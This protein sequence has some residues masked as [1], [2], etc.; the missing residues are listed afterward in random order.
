MELSVENSLI[1]LDRRRSR[2]E[3]NIGELRKALQHWQCWE[4]E[5]EGLKEEVSALGSNASSR[6]IA[7]VGSN[8]GATILDEKDVQRNVRTIENQLQSAEGKLASMHDDQELQEENERDFPMLEI[9]EELDDNGNVISSSTSAAKDEAPRLLEALEQAGIKSSGNETLETTEESKPTTLLDGSAATGDQVSSKER[10]KENLS[11]KLGQG[12]ST[13]ASLRVGPKNGPKVA[14]ATPGGSLDPSPSEPSGAI[15]SQEEQ[16]EGEKTR[17]TS[18]PN[19]ISDAIQDR[20]PPLVPNN[21]SPEDATLR[22]EMLDYGL[23]EVGAVVAELDLDDS[24]S[25]FSYSDDEV[26]TDEEDQYTSS[27]D[28]EVEDKFGRTTR[29]VVSEAYRK[30]MEALERSLNAK[31]VQN[32]GPNLIPSTTQEAKDTP[33]Q[34]IVGQKIDGEVPKLKAQQRPSKKS[35]HFADDL[36]LSS[37]TGAS[38]SSAKHVESTETSTIPAEPPLREA[39]IERSPNASQQRAP[40]PPRPQQKVSLFKSMRAAGSLVPGSPAILK[41]STS[42]ITHPAQAQA[43]TQRFPREASSPDQQSS[44]VL[45]STI[46]DRPLNHDSTTLAPTNNDTLTNLDVNLHSQEIA[47][48]YYRRR[49]QRI[50]TERGGFLPRDAEADTLAHAEAHDGRVPLADDEIEYDDEND[51]P[52]KKP[53]LFR[54]ARLARSGAL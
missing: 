9:R 12:K 20:I 39:I 54:Q 23:S 45:A 48:E 36:D 25:Q 11:T 3:A 29:R 7:A 53:S 31:M 24:A 34:P 42:D 37:P 17:N 47:S 14:P 19:G 2:F 30:E 18:K 27:A 5:Y 16:T 21:E 8:F 40:S 15:P 4:A 28:D 46:I 44:H 6:E 41:P 33:R 32:V 52:G 1:D 51:R 10:P 26:Y 22:R 43:Q 38:E 35:V 49:N 13:T 50:Q